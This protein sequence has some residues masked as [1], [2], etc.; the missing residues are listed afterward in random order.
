M[1][2]YQKIIHSFL[3]G[4]IDGLEEKGLIP[5]HLETQISHLFLFP[6]TVY[7]ICKR[8]NDFFNKDFRNL[9][10]L[11][12]RIDFYKNDFFLNNYF[13]PNVY[14]KIY[15]VHFESDDV[16]I[17]DNI[18]NAID[19]IMKMR[20]IDLKY[21]LSSLL[22]EDTLDLKD[23]QLM[24]YQQTKEVGR[25]PKQPKSDKTYYEIFIDRIDDVRLWMYSAPSYFPKNKTD[26]ICQIMK[27]YVER[28]KDYFINFDK[29]KYVVALDNHSDNMFYE[30]KQVFFLDIYPPKEDW[31]VGSSQL[32]IY[33]PATDVLILKGK[34]YAKAMI[35]G[36]KDYYGS[37]DES[38][39]IFYFLY[40]AAIQAISLY[41]LSGNSQMKKD[42]S[43]VYKKFVLEKAA[44]LE[45]TT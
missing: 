24:G 19:V 16:K 28:N 36:C 35:Q 14:L 34:E 45:K 39:E 3:N 27:N 10:D 15:G 7:K 21:N 38:H 20:R 44:E 11:K 42:D 29:N 30:N 31:M 6:K 32:N 4:N 5:E 23:F 13:S 33:R 22:H 43:L 9:S 26:R 41:N 8:D 17:N 2:K 40:S 12:T 1:D 37:L 25:Y 18:D